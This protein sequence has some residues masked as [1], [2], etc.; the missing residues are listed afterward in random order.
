MEFKLVPT[1]FNFIS[2]SFCIPIDEGENFVKSFLKTKIIIFS[3]GG[4]SCCNT[5]I[6]PKLSGN[7]R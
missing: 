7:I 4:G 3:S 5:P 6:A 2:K 1:G